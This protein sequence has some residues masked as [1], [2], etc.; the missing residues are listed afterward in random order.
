[1]AELQHD[2]WEVS[3]TDFPWHGSTSDRLRY[4]LGYAVLAPSGHNTQPWLFRVAGNA[5]ELYVDRQRALPAVDPLGREMLMSCGT[6]L[7]HLEVAIRH[8][9]FTPLVRTFPDLDDPDLIA[10]VQLGPERTPSIE[11][12]RLFMAI[13]RRRTNRMP[14]APR[15]VPPRELEV[16]R[17]VARQQGA[18]LHVIEDR[19]GKRQLADLIAAAN[20]Q[21]GAD[22]TYRRELA[23]WLRVTQGTD[24]IPGAGT[25]KGSVVALARSFYIRTFDWGEGEAERDRLLAE[26]SPALLVLST[27]ADNAVEWVAA[28]RA[29]DA[30]LLAAADFGLSVSFFNQPIQIPELRARLMTLLDGPDC[31]Q[32]VLRMGYGEELR[33]T[34]RRPVGSMLATNRYL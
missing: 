6:A 9:G 31:P 30:L 32:V 1:M 5:I 11:E 14:F 33:P 34:P 12:H 23:D 17:G 16:L 2:P 10:F 21:L 18:R 15:P 19:R 29:L 27:D 13:K 22:P 28:G 3:E 7:Y 24:G 8:F 25:G 4:L 20:L 26:E